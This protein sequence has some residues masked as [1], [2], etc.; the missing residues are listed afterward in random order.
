VRAC[1]ADVANLGATTAVFSA[2]T[3]ETGTLTENVLVLPTGAWIADTA[4]RSRLEFTKLALCTFMMSGSRGILARWTGQAILVCCLGLVLAQGADVA[5]DGRDPIFKCAFSSAGRANTRIRSFDR[6]EIVSRRAISACNVAFS[7][8]MLAGWTG[9]THFGT[10]KRRGLQR[11]E[12]TLG[13]RSRG[14]LAAVTCKAR[15]GLFG[16]VLAT[17]AVRALGCMGVGKAACWAA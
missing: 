5:A 11:T 17:R 7:G 12:R 16:A 15:S 4:T 14:I 3:N 1:R 2:S 10:A 8:R 13:T 6:H 9:V